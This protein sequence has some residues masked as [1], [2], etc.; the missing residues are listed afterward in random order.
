[1]CNTS[2]REGWLGSGRRDVVSGRV[3]GGFALR[4]AGKVGAGGG[5]KCGKGGVLGHLAPHLWRGPITF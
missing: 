4:K 1:M 3:G 5:G 2:N